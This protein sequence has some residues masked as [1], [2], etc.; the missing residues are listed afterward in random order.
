[1][2]YGITGASGTFLG[3]ITQPLTGRVID[4][5]GYEIPFVAASM[6]YALAI[7]LLLSAGKIERMKRVIAPGDAMTSG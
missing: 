5:A 2:L 4:K 6:L 1:M 7:V 3:A